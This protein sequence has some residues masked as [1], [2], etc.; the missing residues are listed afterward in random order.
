MKL[1]GGTQASA[2]EPHSV[3]Q[4]QQYHQV[5]CRTAQVYC[6]TAAVL[7]V[8]RG[9]SLHVPPLRLGTP[10]GEI[11]PTTSRRGTVYVCCI[12]GTGAYVPGTW[13][14]IEVHSEEP[15]NAPGSAVRTVIQ[16]ESATVNLRQGSREASS[17]KTKEGACPQ[18]TD[19]QPHSLTLRSRPRRTLWPPP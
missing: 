6:C 10:P 7:G 2:V 3:T 19:R 8:N 16:E 11:K 12:P 18:P 4:Q 15:M 5:Y 1:Q 17:T 13:C 9:H 14:V